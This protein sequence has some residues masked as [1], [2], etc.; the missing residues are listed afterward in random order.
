MIEASWVWH[1]Y[2]AYISM[3]SL[4][5]TSITQETGDVMERFGDINQLRQKLVGYLPGKGREP[6]TGTEKPAG[7]RA[8]AGKRK[9]G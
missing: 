2:S 4:L 3:F 6:S 1:S 7:R 8:P 5:A 9:P